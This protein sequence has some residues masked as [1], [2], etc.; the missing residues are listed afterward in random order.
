MPQTSS[1][2]KEIGNNKYEVFMLP[3][4]V[5]MSMMVDIGKVMGPALEGMQAG[6]SD[7]DDQVL[8]MKIAGALMGGLDKSV[9]NNVCDK[10]AGVTHVNGMPL[11][12]VFESHFMGKMGELLQWLIFA[13][14]TQYADFLSVLGIASGLGRGETVEEA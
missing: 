3:P 9:L 11:D 14:E 6:S 2:T 7:G 5:S 13:L 1:K 4:R 8:Y 10:L 12:K